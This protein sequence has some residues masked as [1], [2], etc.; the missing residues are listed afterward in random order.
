MNDRSKKPRQFT[1]YHA[2]AMF[3]AFFGIVMAVNFTMATFAVSG[4]GGT[5]VDNSYVAS[6]K[7]NEWLAEGRAQQAYGWTVSKPERAGDKLQL[8]ITDRDGAAL[9]NADVAIVA[10]HPVGHTEPFRIDMRAIGNGIYRSSAKIPA[11]RWKLKI[12]I[13]KN[14]NEYNMMSEI[15]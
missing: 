2:T 1:G 13:R 12:E 4:F 5:V 9:D 15:K 7:Y 14:G 11:G 8:N 3:V 6:Q 10:D